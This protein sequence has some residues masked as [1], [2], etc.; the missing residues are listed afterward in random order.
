M[1]V[2]FVFV[3]DICNFSVYR[4]NEQSTLDLNNQH[5]LRI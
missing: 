2:I 1:S 3:S 5:R 4:L